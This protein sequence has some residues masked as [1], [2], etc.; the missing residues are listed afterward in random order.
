M[1]LYSLDEFGDFEGIKQENKPVFIAGLIYDD[2][3][4]DNE[5]ANERKRIEAYYK[6][7]I[8]EVKTE[9]EDFQYPSALHA[10][11]DM[12]RNS[13]IVKPVKQKIQAT[14]A[15]FIRKGTYQGER[16]NS[17][18]QV[19]LAERTGRYH[20]F[21][22]LKSDAGKTKLLQDRANILAKDDVGSNLYFHMA[23]ELISRL[24]FHN[25]VISEINNIWL[26]IATRSSGDLEL[27]DPLVRTYKE[28]GYKGKTRSNKIHFN[29]TNADVY[30]SVIAEEIIDTE[31]SEIQISEFHVVPIAYMSYDGGDEEEKARVANQEFLFG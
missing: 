3:N 29:L 4:N 16:L 30:R 28:L 6:A 14:L 23:S 5:I 17:D 24:S 19:P 10:N 9:D 27:T 21:A 31:K 15:E 7:V 25:P 22:I 18:A 12:Q 8:D 20:L 1:L 26:D 13:T 2:K 11:W